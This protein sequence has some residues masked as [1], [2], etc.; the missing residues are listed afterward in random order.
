MNK[1][2]ATSAPKID[3]VEPDI[4]ATRTASAT[5]GKNDAPGTPDLGT[6]G[7]ISRIFGTWVRF[8]EPF[9]VTRATSSIR[10]PPIPR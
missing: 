8:R 9:L 3:E 2:P 5:K 6:R 4:C 7:Q 10:T 1:I